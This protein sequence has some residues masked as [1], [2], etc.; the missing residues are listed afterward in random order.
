M[1]ASAPENAEED[2]FGIEPLLRQPRRRRSSML[3][4][5]IQ[6]QQ[7]SAINDPT[8]RDDLDIS[9]DTPRSGPRSHAYLAYPEFGRT[10]KARDEV[11]TLNSYDLMDD[12]DIP[13]LE[14]GDLDRIVPKVSLVGFQSFQYSI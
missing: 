4:R 11:S 12:N 8:R 13:E 5:W 3:D 9:E 6:D 1:E 10:P 14:V 2:V 7:T